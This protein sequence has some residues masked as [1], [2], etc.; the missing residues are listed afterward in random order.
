MQSGQEWRGLQIRF[1]LH[2]FLHVFVIHRATCTVLIP[3]SLVAAHDPTRRCHKSM[4]VFFTKHTTS[5]HLTGSRKKL[6]AVVL[7][8]YLFL[9]AW[10]TPCVL[11]IHDLHSP[12]LEEGVQHWIS[13]R[14]PAAIRPV[15]RFIYRIWTFGQDIQ[16]ITYDQAT[17]HKLA[18]CSFNPFQFQYPDQTPAGL[19]VCS[20]VFNWFYT[21]KW[22]SLF[23]WF[24]CTISAI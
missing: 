18:A 10:E 8:W 4:Q 9:R 15:I 19:H 13:T 7:V 2:D 1:R 16:L 24:P 11:L 3:L 6:H 14:A 17:K 21:S 22:C 12:C 5:I 23:S 20:Y